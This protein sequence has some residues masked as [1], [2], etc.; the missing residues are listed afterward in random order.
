MKSNRTYFDNTNEVDAL[1][2]RDEPGSGI[3]MPTDPKELTDDTD[4][5]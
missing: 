1:E 3:S 4:L 5:G 2:L